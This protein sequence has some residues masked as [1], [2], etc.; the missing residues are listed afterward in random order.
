MVGVDFS[1]GDAFFFTGHGDLSWI[2]T[3]FEPVVTAEYISSGVVPF[4]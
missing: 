4:H 2:P 1:Q 3:E